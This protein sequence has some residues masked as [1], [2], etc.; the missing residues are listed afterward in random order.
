MAKTTKTTKPTKK[1]ALKPP[2]DHTK[3]T[4]ATT[5]RREE[6]LDGL[7]DSQE[8]RD[9]DLRLLA[10]LLSKYGLPMTKAADSPKHAVK[11][12]HVSKPGSIDHPYGLFYIPN[13]QAR[14]LARLYVFGVREQHDGSGQKG[15]K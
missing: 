12:V 6:L 9:A 7:F 5:E 10:L 1:P 13:E 4:R 2:K 11:F 3:D 14:G 8:A 15:G